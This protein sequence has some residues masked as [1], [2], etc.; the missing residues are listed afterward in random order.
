M[1]LT[2]QEY[3]LQDILIVDNDFHTEITSIEVPVDEPYRV[4][5]QTPV[6][7]AFSGTGI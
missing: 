5:F 1:V 3:V 7:I 6:P 2:V 4:L